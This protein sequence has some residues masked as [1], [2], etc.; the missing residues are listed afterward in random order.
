[1]EKIEK[2]HLGT[3]SILVKNRQAHAKEV[4]DILTENGHL[5]MARLGVNVQRSCVEN[6]TGF[7]TV[8]VEGTS[9][10]IKGLAD[11]IDS[12]YGIVSKYNILTD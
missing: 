7:I 8:A 4:Q 11:K 3:I 6:C 5:I 2:K 9:A 12:L 1:M 10:E